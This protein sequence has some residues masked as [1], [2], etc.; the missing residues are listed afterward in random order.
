MQPTVTQP[1]IPAPAP[2]L[3]APTLVEII[4]VCRAQDSPAGYFAALYTHVE[5]AIAT[6]LREK[7]FAEPQMLSRVN[8]VF[9]GRYFDAFQS[10]RR[11][12]PTTGVWKAAFDAADDPHLCVVQH[13]LLGMNAHINFDLAIAVN[14]ALDPDELRTFEPDFVL[15]NGL[16]ASLVE[17]VSADIATF[18]P[19]LAWINRIGDR[20]ED[21]I[22]DFSM[23]LARENAWHMALELSALSGGAR[24][25][26]IAGFDS[27]AVALAH[28]IARPR[29]IARFV[30]GAIRIGERGSVASIIDDLLC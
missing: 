23:R 3:S 30:A 24:D 27:R 15:M 22:I 11:G 1:I 25:H 26:A 8:E 19:L 12:L 20:P 4:D 13:L 2:A 16:L 28:A 5:A 17:D 29:G 6:A 14:D 21:V 9:L 18:W 10:R 7:R